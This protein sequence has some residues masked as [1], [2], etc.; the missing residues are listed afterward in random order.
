MH[1]FLNE[2]GQTLKLSP[3]LIGNSND[4]AYHE[5]SLTNRQVSSSSK[6]FVNNLLGNKKLSKTQLSKIKQSSRFVKRLLGLL[7]KT[8]L[9]LMKMCSNR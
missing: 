1:N 3:N 6:T 2:T 5:L 9:L 8:G 7:I 4:E